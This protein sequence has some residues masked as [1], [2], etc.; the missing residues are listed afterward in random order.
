M[1]LYLKK[2]KQKTTT[3]TNAREKNWEEIV[4][5]FGIDTYIPLF[6]K[7]ITNKVLLCSTGNLAQCYVAAWME[8]E[9][10]GEEIHVHVWMS[11]IHVYAL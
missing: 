10:R 3:T 1:Q 9:L 2:K 8:G 7:W 6:L 5:E 4:R 11:S